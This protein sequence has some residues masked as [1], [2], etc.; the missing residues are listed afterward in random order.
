MKRLILILIVFVTFFVA[1][2][3]VV[4]GKSDTKNGLKEQFSD[5]DA[6]YRSNY[7]EDK[8]IYADGSPKDLGVEYSKDLV[9]A[10]NDTDNV[11]NISLFEHDKM[12]DIVL[13]KAFKK[14]EAPDSTETPFDAPAGFR[15]VN[16]TEDEAVR[17]VDYVV[18]RIN[19]ASEKSF[20]ALDVQSYRK[21]IKSNMDGTYVHRYV[22]NLFLV[23]EDAKKWNDYSKD[24]A[25]IVTFDGN[26]RSIRYIRLLGDNTNNLK[27]ISP[28]EDDHYYKIRNELHLSEPYR[29]NEQPILMDEETTDSLVKHYR[30]G[31]Q[32]VEAQ[33]FSDAEKEQLRDIPTK[34]RCD[35]V[36][37]IWDFPPTSDSDCPFY[38]K[39]KNYN[40]NRG[41][42]RTDGRCELPIGMKLVG[43][44]YASKDPV[45]EPW[46]Y[47]CKIG[48][49]GMPGSTGPCCEE[50][51]NRRLYPNLSS[52][53]Y[54]FRDDEVN[55]G[56]ARKELENKGLSW[57]KYANNR[58]E[59]KE[60][61]LFQPQKQPVFNKFV[62]VQGY[63]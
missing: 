51:R 44:R 14:I 61:S 58:L 35:A 22:I 41:G 23:E 40:N 1:F 11:V 3:S 29:T 7:R 25:V 28:Y 19:S 59:V 52:P 63:N 54:A 12:L 26:K 37:G 62:G 50:Q 10:H 31:I 55:R 60:P 43:Y 46:C 13:T 32:T 21:E 45:N 57:R 5:Q 20:K 4:K 47:N 24:V 16:S 39:N 15:K 30:R 48:H 33:C 42:I 8:L 36:K 56:H 6:N 2:T 9:V 53:D 18:K 38:R 34:E 49:D 17:A 27:T